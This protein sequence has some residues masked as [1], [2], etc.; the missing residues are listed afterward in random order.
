M[1][2]QFY[3]DRAGSLN[4]QLKQA[5]PDEALKALHRKKPGRH[6]LIAFRQL[7]LLI[8]LPILIFHFLDN[9]FVWLPAAV[10]QGVVIF[11]FTVLVHEAVHKCIFNRDRHG[12]SERLG[13]F[14]AMLSGLAYD[15]FKR[16]HLDHHFQ[17]GSTIADPKRAHL[18]PK[19][20][21]R[22]F[23]LLYFTP[24]LFPIYFRAAAIAAAD[25]PPELRRRIAW[26][27]RCTIAFHLS[28]MAGL[29]WI[30]PWLALRAWVIPVFLVFPVAFTINRLGQHYVIDPDDIAQWSTLMRPNFAWNFLFLFSSYHLEHHYFP[31]VPCYRLGALQ[32]LLLPFY[33]ERQ[34]PVY[35]Y[36]QLIKLW[37]WDNH[38]PHARPAAAEA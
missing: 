30:S 6:F 12:L 36:G 23:K 7:A 33:R 16:W 38:L 2:G 26:Q 10:L 14:Y 1:A 18:S 21:A 37:L 8:G 4:R 13:Q 5:L 29:A 22:W 9:P 25:Y 31:A 32:R 19:I 20:N 3:Y 34:V 28:V 17:L 24:A 11:S 15:Q 35:G 27:R